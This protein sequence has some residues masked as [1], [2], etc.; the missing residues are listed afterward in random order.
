MKNLSL[1]IAEDESALREQLVE[2][3]GLMIDT[4][5]E[6]KDG[7]EAYMHYQRY[8][9]DIIVTDLEMPKLNGLELIAKIRAKDRHTQIIILSAHSDTHYLQKAVELN[10]TCYLIKPIPT[11]QLRESIIKA[12]AN[13]KEQQNVVLADNYCWDSKKKLLYYEDKEVKLSH[14]E[15]LFIER[16]IA[17]K[18]QTVSFEDIHNYIYDMQEY[19]QDA[20]S[21]LVKRLRKKTTKNIAVSC[22]KE[23]Y[24]IP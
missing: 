21:S 24:K 13:I 19:S 5:Y 6:A 23:G 7:E 4:V 18:S 1:L 22:Y 17:S 15:L 12:M 16:L 3:L 2:S 11:G 10:L 8:Q 9:P 14:Y 20:I